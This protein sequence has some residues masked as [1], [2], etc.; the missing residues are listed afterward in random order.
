M[1]RVF[2]VEDEAIIRETLRDTVPWGQYGYNFAGEA[3]DGEIAL[4]M[5]RQARP[6]VLITDIRMPFMDG[7]ALSRLVLKEFPQIKVIIISG[8]DDFEY[9]RQAIDI[10]V[11]R[12]LLKP[13]TKNKLLDVLVHIR[14]KLDSEGGNYITQFHLEAQEY[15]QF[16][17]K[18]FFE[19]LT[20]GQLS[21]QQIY[22][23]AGK[24]DLDLQAQSY[25]IA[26]F[27][28]PVENPED[29]S[30]CGSRI[31][32]ALLE[33]FMKYSEYILLRW[34]LTA[35]AVIIKGDG[36]RMPEYVER[37]IQTVKGQYDSSPDPFDWYVAVGAPTP[38]LSALPE[39]YNEVSRLWSYRYILP[40]QHILTA[41]TV[42]NF[43][44]IGSDSSL[45]RL[46]ASKVNPALLMGV[47]KGAVVDEIGG[48]VDEYVHSVSE[49]LESK[50]F[51]QYLMLSV[52]FT[53]A[54]YAVSL[55]VSQQDFLSGLDC[56]DMVGQNITAAELKNYMRQILSAAVELRDSAS[57]SQY[58]GLM[59]R[60]VDYI[61]RHYAEDTLSLNRVAREVNI[62]ANYLSAVFSQ[63]KGCTL[64]E[65]ITNK[66]MEKARELLRNSDRRSGEIAQEV[67]YR[68]PHYFSFIFKKTQ[69]CTPRDYRA[70][71]GKHT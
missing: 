20:E 47:M 7:L 8:Y 62:S 2:L 45:D 52:R 14:E 36:D 65:Y 69:G 39:C 67:G 5:I 51:C 21:V 57:S 37:C 61:D 33:H 28:V 60:A 12:Y 59:K 1:L 24:L 38:R 10:G 18:R 9:A 27:S 63:E 53:A 41:K 48:F 40:S 58:R 30:E 42:G 70:G 29:F 17:R 56:L 32:D 64:T 4:P 26:F 19:Q 23:E 46:D 50:S 43:T 55:G 11:E 16:A 25:T 68:D 54:E 15:E 49:A 34:N 66:R 3:G 6:D 31:R 13:I 35:Y 44:G 71:R 22:E